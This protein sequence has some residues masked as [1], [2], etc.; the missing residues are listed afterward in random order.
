MK[1]NKLAWQCESSSSPV[2]VGVVYRRSR[3]SLQK[4]AVCQ[5]YYNMR[6][7]E[8]LLK[9]GV[10][11]VVLESRHKIKMESKSGPKN[12]PKLYLNWDTKE[13]RLRKA[14]AISTRT[15]SYHSG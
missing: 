12:G 10:S 5:Y 14:L 3:E 9:E 8:S 1:K 7:I 4:S 6:K 11:T 2:V 13:D 15:F